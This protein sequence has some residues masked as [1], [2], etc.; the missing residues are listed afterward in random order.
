MRGTTRAIRL[1]ARLSNELRRPL[2]S[3]PRE[4]MARRTLLPICL[5]LGLTA[6][7]AGAQPPEPPS[8]LPSPE[9]SA[10]P[11]IA[12][13]PAPGSAPAP[14]PAP[15]PNERRSYLTRRIDGRP[16][17]LDG[18]PDEAA[19]DQVEWSGGFL[20][21]R[22]HEGHPPSHPTEFKILYDDE[23][24][25]VAYRAWD[26]EPQRIESR[27]ARRDWFPGDWV[28]I[29]ID[30][31]GDGRTAFSFT[32]SVS[33]V[34]GDEYVSE[35]GNVWDTSWDPVWDS[36]TAIDEQ[37]WTAEVRIPLSQLRYDAAPGQVWG[38]QVMRRIFRRQERSI[39]Q[40][41]PEDS[42]GWVSSFGE[43]R[44]LEGLP[45]GRQIEILPYAVASHERYAAEAGNPFADGTESELDG[46]LD[47]KLGLSGNLILD[48]TL[49]PDFGQVEA[50]PAEVNLSG[51]ETFFGERR[52]FFIEGSEVLRYP[53]A[54]A[55]TGGSFTSDRLF[56][57][58]RI[59]RSPQGRPSAEPDAFVELP[60]AT[61]I[62]T[63]AK[64][65]GRTPGGLS[66]GALEA[67]TGEEWALIHEDACGRR[68]LIE[69]LTS[70]FAG[71]LQ[72]EW[73][74]GRT[75]LGGMATAV[76]RRAAG[77]ATEAM[78]A[79][80]FAGGVDF[81]HR[82]AGRV[83]GLDLR[84]LASEV[85]GGR[86]AL[87]A[88]QA[89]PARYFQRPDAGHVELDS[90]RTSLS[91]HAG[92]AY[93][94]K[95]SGRWR[96]QTG[97]AWRSPG[98]EVNDL[99]YLRTADEI[100]QTTWVGFYRTQPLS[101][102]HSFA[103]NANEWVYWD[104]GG[105]NLVQ[106]VNLNSNAT[107]RNEWGLHTGCSRTLHCESNTLLRGGPA[108]RVPGSTDIQISLD[109]DERSPLI[110]EA[111]ISRST[112]D[113]GSSEMTSAGVSLSW[114]PASGLQ[115]TVE[116]GYSES[117]SDLQYVDRAEFAGEPRYLFAEI[118][119][120]TAALTL[121][122]DACLT[123]DLTIQYYAQPFLASGSYGEFKR[124]TDPLADRY[125]DRLRRFTTGDAPQGE[126]VHDEAAG[127]YLIDEDRDG[128]VDYGFEDPDFDYKEFN[129]NLV[130]RWEYRPGSTLY[131]VWSQGRLGDSPLG[132][133][134]LADDLEALF[135]LHPRN[136]F[137][138]KVSRWF[139][140]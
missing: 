116:P 96:F 115:L 112:G 4:P 82:W 1:G 14:D 41:I 25:Y 95:T 61:S 130:V 39:W 77:E 91:G 49:N 67:V 2:P 29:N 3:G 11:E 12:T 99:G 104:F 119:Q 98:F 37:G 32:A 86:E 10:V 83:W 74:E 129:S 71:R 133:L 84:L 17:L 110:F 80:A 6:G 125:E 31:R 23:A 27:L 113:E 140:W 117:R 78:H 111:E 89:A 85:R 7:F 137:L 121:R 15:G 136:T 26:A 33:G 70:Y 94:G 73:H 58:R 21:R 65:S 103:F 42:P 87:L 90:T 72:Q 75:L 118:R 18:R 60:S 53:L 68:E 105:R 76:H 46:G 54:E 120:Q 52:P 55:I 109:S 93:L 114:R 51:F 106:E 30:S 35:D 134:E 13:A 59:G 101:I 24:L 124:V 28:E 131:F 126:I 69:P 48:L 50:D 5:L 88:T 43:L 123:P 9:A 40:F 47:A 122:I 108:M 44:G 66:I 127:G 79:G 19:W 135:D 97:C 132:E 45:P 139:S 36:A 8:G 62:L 128:T 56:Y 64:L 138:I 81:S 16:P 34:R 100:N 102:F 63:A 92:S 107:F 20:Q 57:S 38:I 22:P